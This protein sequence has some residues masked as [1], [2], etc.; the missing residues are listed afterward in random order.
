MI[1]II[2]I[3]LLC[4]DTKTKK[5]QGYAETYQQLDSDHPLDMLKTRLP[6]HANEIVYR[7][8]PYMQEIQANFKIKQEEFLNWAEKQNWEVGKISSPTYIRSISIK[9]DQMR[10]VEVEIEKGY[11]FEKKVE[12]KDKPEMLK[13][14]LVIYFDSD[15]SRCHYR[16]AL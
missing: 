9:D 14:S 6:R 7:L 16:Y 8:F 2:V 5:I 13:S 12:R 11:S 10:D 4:F 1:L 15:T 3:P